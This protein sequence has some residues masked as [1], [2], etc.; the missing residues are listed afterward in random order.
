MTEP[1]N[2]PMSPRTPDDARARARRTAAWLGVFAF[3]VFVGF[4]VFSAL[5]R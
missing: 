2:T 5:T 1:L 3:A 4:M